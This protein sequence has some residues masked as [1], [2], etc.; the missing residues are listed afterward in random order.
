MEWQANGLREGVSAW[1]EGSITMMLSMRIPFT[2][3]LCST[4]LW[5][6]N[7][8]KCILQASKTSFGE[9]NDSQGRIL[10]LY[11]WDV[12][13]IRGLLSADI[14]PDVISWRANE[15]CQC[16]KSKANWLMTQFSWD[17]ETIVSVCVNYVQSI[18]G[19]DR[20]SRN[21]N[22][23]SLVCSFVRL[24]QTCLEQSIFFILAHPS[25]MGQRANGRDPRSG[26]LHIFRGP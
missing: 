16:Q 12:W 6:M 19:S 7:D 25:W 8:I 15:Q 13:Q 5:K 3:S 23:R 21:A 22:V 11:I 17:G 14:K 20:G 4:M 24:V 9:C 2:G 10:Q 26:I 1:P 18:F